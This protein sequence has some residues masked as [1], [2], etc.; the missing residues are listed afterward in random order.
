MTH[1]TSISK[2]QRPRI[3]S[4]PLRFAYVALWALW[5][6]AA[7]AQTLGRTD[8]NKGLFPDS[9]IVNFEGLLDPPAGKYGFLRVDKNG[10]FAWPDGKRAKFWGVNISNKSV[11][12]DKDTIDK[13]VDVL[14]RAGT[15]MVRFE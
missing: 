12:A 11:W 14:A 1:N 13:V 7:G 10:R 6:G 8:P 2:L 15:N 9:S 4:G 3:R 5:A